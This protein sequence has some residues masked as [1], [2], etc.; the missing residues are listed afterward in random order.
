VTLEVINSPDSLHPDSNIMVGP[1]TYYDVESGNAI[2]QPTR[3]FEAAGDII[4]AVQIG[5]D[6]VFSGGF[7]LVGPCGL[8]PT[9]TTT[10]TMP[11]ATTT[12][13]TTTPPP[14][15][16]INTGGG[17]CADG[18]CDGLPVW[19]LPAVFGLAALSAAAF[20]QWLKSKSE[21]A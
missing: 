9:P 5:E 1:L 19:M 4:V 21:E 20:G 16:G 15:D 12:T 18:A 3:Q 11:G 6:K 13:S 14:V 10:T 2:R 8:P 17:A 7:R